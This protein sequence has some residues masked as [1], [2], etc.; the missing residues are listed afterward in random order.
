MDH[1][2]ANPYLSSASAKP[3]PKTNE[4]PDD[5]EKLKIPRRKF[6]LVHAAMCPHGLGRGQW[7][8]RPWVTL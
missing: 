3:Y 7:M 4:K 2:C 8:Q 1:R 6:N 5:S